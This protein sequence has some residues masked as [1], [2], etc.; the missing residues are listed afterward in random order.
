MAVEVSLK[1]NQTMKP[2]IILC[3]ALVLNDILSG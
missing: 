3:H 2:K 1:D